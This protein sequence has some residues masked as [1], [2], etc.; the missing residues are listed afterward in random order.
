MKDGGKPG[1]LPTAKP[2]EIWLVEHAAA[3]PLFPCDRGALTSAN[4]VLYERALEPVA[5]AVLPIGAYAEPLPPNGPA[6]S[7][8][9]LGFAA[10]GWSV[11]QLVEARGER[12]ARLGRLSEALAALG[13]AG[14]LPVLVVAKAAPDRRWERDACLRTLPGL[15]DEWADR[16]LLTLIFG[17]LAPRYPAPC[18]AVAA[19]GLAG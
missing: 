10:E 12:R 2:G 8:R 11:A 18:H 4:V 16:G 1:R 9:A 17:P 6:V 3:A 7:P 13:V 14:E 15:A 5:A 19:N